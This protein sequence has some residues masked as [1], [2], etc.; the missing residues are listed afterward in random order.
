MIKK[1]LSSRGIPTY[2]YY[3]KRDGSTATNKRSNEQS[4]GHNK[5]ISIESMFSTTYINK[6]F[7]FHFTEEKSN[8][9]R[10]KLHLS[11]YL[12]GVH[13]FFHDVDE[14]TKKR[15]QRFVYAYV[16]DYFMYSCTRSRNFLFTF[17]FDGDI[18]ETVDTDTTTHILVPGNCRD[19]LALQ[20][21]CP[22]ARVI[23]IEWLDACVSHGAKLGTDTYEM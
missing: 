9:G 11:N 23:N 1:Y 22:K 5:R 18:D 14:Q 13:I 8:I 4:Y 7:L 21:T 6:Y 3:F 15:L 12:S 10:L 16:D 20:D 19:I 2:I 17:S